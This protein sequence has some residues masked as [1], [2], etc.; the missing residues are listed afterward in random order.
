M[1][2]SASFT[3]ELWFGDERGYNATLQRE[4]APEVKL[5]FGDERGY[6]ATPVLDALMGE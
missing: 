3:V 1:V 6:N 2:Y 4:L 5:W